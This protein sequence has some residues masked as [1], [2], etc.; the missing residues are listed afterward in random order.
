M[1]TFTLEMRSYEVVS[2]ALVGGPSGGLLK[3]ELHSG[4]SPFHWCHD[5][6][7]VVPLPATLATVPTSLTATNINKQL[8]GSRRFSRTRST[9]DDDAASQGS[10]HSSASRSV[11]A[12]VTMT[13]G[14]NQFCF[15]RTYVV[16]FK[17]VV[18][19]RVI[20]NIVKEQHHPS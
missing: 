6:C 4:Y 20:F 8:A 19:D 11:S 14:P 10:G 12:A 15:T 13:I 16:R 7:Q 18:T 1:L 17:S 5:C 9:K 3:Q 2:V